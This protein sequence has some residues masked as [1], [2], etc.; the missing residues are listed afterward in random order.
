MDLVI[1]GGIDGMDVLQAPGPAILDK[2]I[3][4]LTVMEIILQDFL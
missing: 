4:I 3:S 1:A 2:P